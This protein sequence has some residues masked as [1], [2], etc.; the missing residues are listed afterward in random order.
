MEIASYRWK[1]ERKLFEK[2]CISAKDDV[3]I[4]GIGR[5]CLD[6]YATEVDK[7]VAR[8]ERN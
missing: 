2:K 3:N 6:C 8:F 7:A 1:R 5:T 4:A